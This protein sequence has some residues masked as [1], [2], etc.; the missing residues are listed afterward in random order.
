M[1]HILPLIFCLF[2]GV[3]ELLAQVGKDN[4]VMENIVPNPSFEDYS[5]T[6]I[7]W[8][9]KGKHFTSVVKYWSAPTSASPDVFGPKVRVPTHWK[10]KGFGG[11]KARTGTSMVGTTL[12]GCEDGKPHCREYVQ[13]QLKEPLVLGQNYYTEFWVSDLPRSMKVNNIGVHFSDEKIDIKGDPILDFRPEVKAK[14]IVTSPSG[15][16]VKIAGRFQAKTEAN[17]LIIGNF[18]TDTLTSMKM[19]TAPQ[20]LNYAYYYIDD[21][22]LRKEQPILSVPIKEDDLTK[23]TLE[24]GKVVRLKNIFFDHDKAVLLPRSYIELNKLVK[25]M[26]E[27]P[28]MVIEINGHTDSVGKDRYNIY[29]SRKRAKAVVEY[30]VENKISRNRM[31]Y[32]GYGSAQP[33]ADNDTKEGRQLNRRVEFLV[34][35]K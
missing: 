5:S 14:D 35:K 28:S 10:E 25:L 2:F 7:G 21:V 18:M 9:Y 12:Y 31:R 19:S 8:F 26:N 13:I 3:S 29:L 11:Q 6:P 33:I 17:Y 16:W 34:I 15:T 24:E 4:T 32:K 22:L 23:I 30:L 20:P 27:N 1:R